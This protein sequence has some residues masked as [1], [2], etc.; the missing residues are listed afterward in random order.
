MELRASG[1]PLL[2]RLWEVDMLASIM[3]SSLRGR[4]CETSWQGE[5]RCA[6]SWWE[7]AQLTSLLMGW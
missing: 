5:K 7:P 4:S 6:G 1:Y 3:H 2:F